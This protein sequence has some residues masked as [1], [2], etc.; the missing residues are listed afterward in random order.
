MK[1]SLFTF[2]LMTLFLMLLF[3][4]AHLES[5][6]EVEENSKTPVETEN[7]GKGG[8]LEEIVV[9]SRDLQMDEFDKEY[10]TE[11]DL[12]GDG[13]KDTISLRTA[14]NP[15]YDE[16]ISY[17]LHVNEEVMSYEGEMISP[18]FHVTDLLAT[19]NLLEIAVSEEGPS[20]DYAT[21]FYRYMNGKL[22]VLSKLE[23]F[24]GKIPNSDMSGNLIVH[25]D[26]RVSTLS[27][28][29][30][31]QTF[32]Y[33]DEYLL[34]SPTELKHVEKDLYPMETKVTLLKK[35]K[36]VVS[37]SDSSI[38]YEFQPG[39]KAVLLET[40]N[41]SWVS[42]RNEDGEISWFRIKDFGMILDQE[43]NGFSTDFFD[44]LNMAD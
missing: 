23:G 2:F 1:R 14:I 43:E 20:S 16:V 7:G 24:L 3:G 11:A 10:Y 30:V 41:R 39:E 12:D 9:E 26:G 4:C 36:T 21:V 18:L 44:G 6:D 31:M 15:Y 33:E 34:V 22:T 5:P 40:D 13:I 42:I 19:D 37:R 29:Q 28:G 38:A 27:R 35:L 8:I 17:E 32:F 25:G